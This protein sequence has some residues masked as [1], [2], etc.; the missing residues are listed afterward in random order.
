VNES[1]WIHYDFVLRYAAP[2]YSQ[3]ENSWVRTESRD[4]FTN[5]AYSEFSLT[6]RYLVG[7]RIPTDTKP[8]LVVQCSTMSGKTSRKFMGHGY[9]AIEAVIPPTTEGKFVVVPTRLDDGGTT[10]FIFIPAAG[11]SSM[12]F[13]GETL[14]DFLYG[15]ALKH[16]SAPPPPVKKLT[17]QLF[18]IAGS[19]VVVQFDLPDPTTLA[20]ACGVTEPKK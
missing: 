18:D 6:G 16:K 14:T 20:D 3:L 19:Q 8:R 9:L 1:D 17:M 15:H 2:L 13:M 7:P 11:G 5:V 4:A 12:F 10:A